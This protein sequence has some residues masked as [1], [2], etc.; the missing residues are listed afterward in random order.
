MGDE[1]NDCVCVR[2]PYPEVPISTEALRM[3]ARR[4]CEVKPSGKCAVDNDT[5]E[6]YK[7]GG[8]RREQ[9]EMALL[10]S[11]SKFGVGRDAYKRVKVCAF[12][13]A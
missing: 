7:A 11:I 3:R 10:E 2:S 6:A 4:T 1:V 9:L 8:E 13:C 12:L 5:V